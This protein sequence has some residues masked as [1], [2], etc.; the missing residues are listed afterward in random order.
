MNILKKIKNSVSGIPSEELTYSDAS[1]I[2][3]DMHRNIKTD[4]EIE[5]EIIAVSDSSYLVS[6]AA[7]TCVGTEPVNEYEARIKHVERIM[8]RHHESTLEHTNI[9]IRVRYKNG[10]LKPDPDGFKY[11]NCKSTYTDNGYNF[12][13]AGSI[14]GYKHLFKSYDL[15]VRNLIVD[16]IKNCIYVCTEKVFFT[17]LIEDGIMD[18]S[19]FP[20]AVNPMENIKVRTESVGATDTES[21]DVLEY[22]EV[23]EHG[24]ISNEHV[25]VFTTEH[26]KFKYIYDKLVDYGFTVYDVM[27]LAVITVRFKNISRPI[28]MQINRHR[29]AISQE[30]Q[31]YVDYSKAAFIDPIKYTEE[32]VNKKFNVTIFGTSIE[33]TSAE[34]GDKLCSIYHQLIAQGMRKEEARSFLPS[35]VC[36]KLMMTFTYRNLYHFLLMREDRAAQAEVRAVALSLH[37]AIN[38]YDE[39]CIELGDKFMEY[40]DAPKY[41][42]D[43][44]VIDGKE[45]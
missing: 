40:C 25:D 41:K 30:S 23:G 17:D 11:L 45:D 6:A 42:S 37:D 33:L 44:T 8:S 43:K 15:G 27:D 9:V 10:K 34:L 24:L 16:E 3:P 26:R 1:S 12:V 13:V 5:S 31:R 2:I 32:D 4:N 39:S 20:N 18:E 29:N 19:L 14:R 7:R 21:G 28:S 22:G 35:N 36:T 38:K